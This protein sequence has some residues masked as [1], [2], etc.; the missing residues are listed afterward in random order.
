LTTYFIL[1]LAISDFC[2][3]ESRVLIGENV[4][5]VYEKSIDFQDVSDAFKNLISFYFTPTDEKSKIYH[6]GYVY[7]DAS[8]VF[9]WFLLPFGFY[10]IFTEEDNNTA[11]TRELFI[12]N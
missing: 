10:Y 11:L 6:G 7:D 4:S 2:L 8:T 1:C 5:T 3:N 9:Y 12:T